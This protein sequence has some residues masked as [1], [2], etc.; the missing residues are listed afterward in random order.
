MFM[1]SLNERVRSPRPPPLAEAEPIT[2]GGAMSGHDRV[3]AVKY[4]VTPNGP[5]RS[6]EGARD[7]HVVIVIPRTE[8]DTHEYTNISRPVDT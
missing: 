4:H 7:L 2:R 1:F 6:Q 5:R 8:I 3:E